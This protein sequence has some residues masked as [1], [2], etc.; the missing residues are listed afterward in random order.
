MHRCPVFGCRKDLPYH[1]L[2]C[3][4]HWSAVPRPLQ[5]AVNKAWGACA[6]KWDN[7]AYLTARQGA[8]DAVNAKVAERKAA[9]V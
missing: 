8:I 6:G 5:K 4:P 9:Q 2:M 1:I 3:K 7:P